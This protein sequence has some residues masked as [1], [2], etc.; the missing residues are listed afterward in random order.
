MKKITKKVFSLLFVC[1][2]MQCILMLCTSIPVKAADQAASLEDQIKNLVQTV[3]EQANQMTVTDMEAQYGKSDFLTSLYD[4]IDETNKAAGAFVQTHGIDVTMNEKDSTAECI[5][6]VEYEKKDASVTIN[7][8]YAAS[9]FTDLFKNVNIDVVYTKSEMLAQTGQNVLLS[10]AI[11]FTM[12]ILLSFVISLFKYITPKKADVQ[13]KNTNEADAQKM[14]TAPALTA[15]KAND[16]AGLSDEMKL[17]L[18]LAIQNYEEDKQKES[19]SHG[20]A[21]QARS[22]KRKSTN[23]WKRA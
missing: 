8:N 16:A 5:L 6:D 18:A 10:L 22:L 7:I 4:K 11:V 21:Y 14:Q 1:I 13:N 3:F 2:F 9:T 23:K 12:L 15:D 20:D 17:V 19:R